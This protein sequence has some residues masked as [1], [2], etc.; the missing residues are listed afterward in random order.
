MAKVIISESEIPEPLQQLTR[1][2]KSKTY[3]YSCQ[4]GNV[5]TLFTDSKPDRLIKCFKCNKNIKYLR[6]DI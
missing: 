1:S 2:K 4:C 3:I 5:I 6:E